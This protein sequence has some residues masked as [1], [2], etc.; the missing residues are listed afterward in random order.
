MI[1][2]S[3]NKTL[4]SKEKEKGFK[5]GVFETERR[6]RSR[7]DDTIN[8]SYVIRTGFIYKPN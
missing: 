6:I 5:P 8:N 2:F 1:V 4:I 7:A 3:R